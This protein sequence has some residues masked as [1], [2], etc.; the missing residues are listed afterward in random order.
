MHSPNRIDVLVN[1]GSRKD[2]EAI[3]YYVVPSE[4]VAAKMQSGTSQTE[5]KSEWHQL[6]LVDA[7]PYL[8]NWSAFGLAKTAV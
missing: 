6:N 1:I 2:G 3:E 7:K 8:N 5:P 4:V